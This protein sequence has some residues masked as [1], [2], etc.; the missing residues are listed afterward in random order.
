MRKKKTIRHV[1]AVLKRGGIWEGEGESQI[2]LA[3]SGEGGNDKLEK[4]GGRSKFW[5]NKRCGWTN[6]KQTCE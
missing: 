3:K 4:G 5:V 2:R 6:K 1:G